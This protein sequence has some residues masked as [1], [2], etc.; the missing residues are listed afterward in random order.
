MMRTN[1]I[2]QLTSETVIVPVGIVTL[3]ILLT[4]TVI[5]KCQ[6]VLLYSP[7]GDGI[8]TNNTLPIM[9]GGRQVAAA[10]GFPL[11]PGQTIYIE[12]LDLVNVFVFEPTG[13]GTQ[14]LVVTVS[15]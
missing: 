1:I 14:I 13:A 9:I 15:R 2:T 8:Y 3:G 12:I 6:S 10:V 7:L 11:R 5:T 4:S